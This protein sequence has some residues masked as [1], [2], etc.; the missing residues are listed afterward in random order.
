MVGG[1]IAV[2]VSDLQEC[3]DTLAW[4]KIPAVIYFE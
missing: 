4:K 1:S 2:A 3:Q